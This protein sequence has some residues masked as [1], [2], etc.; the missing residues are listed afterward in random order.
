MNTTEN[1]FGVYAAIVT[2]LKADGVPNPQAIEQLTDFMAGRGCHG[3]L[4]LGTTGEGPSFSPQERAQIFQAASQARQSHP[5]LHLL[6]GTGT[7][8]LDETITLTRLAFDQGF[9]GVVVL[10]PYFYRKVSD[11]GLFTWFDTL[12]RKAVPSNGTLLG[13][14]IPPITGIGFSLDLL[15]RLKDAHP[16]SFA[17]IKDSSG[18]PD[19]ARQ[20]GQRFGP[21][22]VVLTG[23]DRLFSL[24]LE[25]HAS[26]CIT[27]MA[28]LFS[29]TLRQVWDAHLAGENPTLLQ[30]KLSSARAILDSFPPMPPL[31]KALLHHL[32]GLPLWPVRPPLLDLPGESIPAI[33]ESL[34]QINT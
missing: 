16:V 26:G 5:A 13:Y 33:L 11:D 8:S 10:P 24:A 22:L 17:G 23:N 34:Q 20:L 27:A 3:I 31:L 29:P 9:D 4:F 28:N 14:H 2:P 1:L 7:P 19:Y 30:G 25:N 21:D 15:A 6:A 18:D 12:L 32:Y